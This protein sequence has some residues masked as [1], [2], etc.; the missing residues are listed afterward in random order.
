MPNLVSAAP[1]FL[2]ADVASTARWYERRLG[3]APYFFPKTAPY[4]FASLC[5]D[6]I[7]IMLLGMQG[8]QKPELTRPGGLWD[9]YIR[10]RGIEK[11]CDE[12]RK[13]LPLKSEL[14]KQFYGNWEFE[15]TDPNGYVLVFSE[16]AE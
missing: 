1:T 9:A 12:V 5:R 13:Q 2:V 11:F 3:F 15:V 7:E 10:M 14:T 8:Y 16:V 6:N 4:V